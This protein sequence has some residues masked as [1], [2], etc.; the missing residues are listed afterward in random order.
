[1]VGGTGT[2]T[3]VGGSGNDV[4]F[5][6]SGAD[7]MFSGT[8]NA[9]MA[10]GSGADLFVFING[11]AGGTDVILNFSHGPD[12]VWLGNYATNAVPSVL[13]GAVTAN[14]STTIMLSDNTHITFAGVSQLTARDF[15]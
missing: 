10:A 12:Q 5:G 3:M 13:G 7:S 6:G 15:V 9:V 14:G 8:G 2:T 11:S 4:M 1:L